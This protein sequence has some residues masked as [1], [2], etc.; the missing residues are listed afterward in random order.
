MSDETTTLCHCWRVTRRDGSVLGFTDHDRRLQ[1]DAQEFEPQS[2]FAQSEAETSLGLAIDSAEI[3]GA[4]SSDL[5]SEEDIDAGLYD[6]ARVET[7]LVDWQVPTE[8]R[9][10]RTSA[11][12]KIIRRDGRLVAEL[13][14]LARHLDRP[15]G[16]YLRR[17]CDA[18]LGDTRCGVT[19]GGIEAGGGVAG[20]HGP[21][22]FVAS[23]LSGFADGWFR[24]GVLTWT[25]GPA[26]SRTMRVDGHAQ[27]L[28]GVVI[29]LSDEV[30]IQLGAAFTMIAGCDKTFHTCRTK[31]AN[32]LNFRG[33]PHL[34]GNDAAYGYV[35]EEGNFDG[36][37]LVR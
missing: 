2:G 32:T 6:S 13:E 9:L 31:F 16:R 25:S 4:L 26:A 17:Q 10:I 37:A 20:L 3:E 12:A 35:S 11:I 8:H 18:E 24:H 21:R 29:L 15:S 1:F 36:G 19:L 7:F 23:G 27:G 30:D 28:G 14:S 5:L 34:S 22:S 33:F